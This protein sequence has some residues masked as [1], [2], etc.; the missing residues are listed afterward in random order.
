MSFSFIRVH[1]CSARVHGF[2][3]VFEKGAKSCCDLDDDSQGAVFSHI[4]FP[5]LKHAVKSH[6]SCE[7]SS[8]SQGRC[9]DRG[10][11]APPPPENLLPLQTFPVTQFWVDENAHSSGVAFN[12][13]CNI[14]L[15]SSS[16]GA[17]Q[18]Q[19][20][21]FLVLLRQK[22]RLTL[23]ISNSFKLHPLLPYFSPQNTDA[24]KPNK[25]ERRRGN[26]FKRNETSGSADHSWISGL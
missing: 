3:F 10:A 4:F 6:L 2:F 17:L 11:H 1:V 13:C 9:L 22:V 19:F 16:G 24:R 14:C 7:R 8:W 23:Y 26:V 12:C 25:A 5:T 20:S 18:R 21:P 15:I